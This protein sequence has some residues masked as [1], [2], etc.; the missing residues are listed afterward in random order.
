MLVEPSVEKV[1]IRRMLTVSFISFLVSFAHEEK[2]AVL[3]LLPQTLGPH[4]AMIWMIDSIVLW[5]AFLQSM[6]MCVVT[7]GE[8]GVNES[9]KEGC[10]KNTEVNRKAAAF[11]VAV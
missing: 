10:T 6:S 9:S 3:C 2:G 5:K 7:Q 8:I 1:A 11:M 4:C